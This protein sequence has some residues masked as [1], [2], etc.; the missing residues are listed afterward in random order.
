M[1]FRYYNLDNEL[2]GTVEYK[3]G[4]LKGLDEGGKETVEMLLE[5]HPEEEH[6]QVI[7]NY[8]RV[9]QEPHYSYETII[10]EYDADEK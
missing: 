8:V 4:E 3:N 7:E 1:K 2:T 5:L 9:K 10:V 6:K